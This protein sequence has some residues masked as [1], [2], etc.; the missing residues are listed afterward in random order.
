MVSH[1]VSELRWSV[2]PCEGMK[3]KGSNLTATQWR[4]SWLL[5]E[6]LST[7]LY[8][9]EQLSASMYCAEQLSTVTAP[10]AW[11]L[12][13]MNLEGVRSSVTVHDEST[14]SRYKQVC[15]VPLSSDFQLEEYWIRVHKSSSDYWTALTLFCATTQRFFKSWPPEFRH[16]YNIRMRFCKCFR[17]GKQ[18]L[19]LFHK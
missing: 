11:K 16:F 17:R 4:F 12:R 3:G 9:A 7:S 19:C 8:C 18:V 14:T 5:A 15:A 6:K 2:T 1:S 13:T 10:W